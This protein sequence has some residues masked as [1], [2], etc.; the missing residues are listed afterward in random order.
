VHALKQ[1]NEAAFGELHRGAVAAIAEI[2]TA[3]QHARAD[4]TPAS[5]MERPVKGLL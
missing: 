2:K 1:A 5:D 4:T 3:M